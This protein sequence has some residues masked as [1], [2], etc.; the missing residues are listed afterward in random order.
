MAGGA[1]RFVHLSLSVLRAIAEESENYGCIGEYYN[2][3]FGPVQP[4]YV[5]DC[6]SYSQEPNWICRSVCK[7]IADQLPKGFTVNDLDRS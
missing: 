7:K 4:R 2:C 6:D 5:F 1:N 3:E